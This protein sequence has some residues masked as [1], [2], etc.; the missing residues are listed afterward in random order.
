MNP[1][2]TVVVQ[3]GLVDRD[4]VKELVSWGL[5]VEIP[6]EMPPPPK[7]LVELNELL[8]RALQHEGLVTVRETD[9]EVLKLF[10]LSQRP[11]TLHVVAG[12]GEA[13]IPVMYAQNTN[14]PDRLEYIIPF[15][16]ESI[17]N[18]MT[19]GETYLRDAQNCQY[20]FSDVRELFF[21]DVKAFMVCQVSQVMGI[22][23]ATPGEESDAK[24]TP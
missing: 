21:G 14:A 17:V 10:M 2:A 9:L 24:H 15:T 7:N 16:S 4:M 22:D 23:Y 1:L 13:D 12:D 8:E 11:G 3:S 19:N 18:E 20:Y 6:E 5:P